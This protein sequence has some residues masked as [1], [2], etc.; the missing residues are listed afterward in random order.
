MGKSL[1]I[2]V[3][4]LLIFI[5]IGATMANDT[6]EPAPKPKTPAPAPKP[7]TPAPAPKPK[8]PAPTPKPK[9]PAPTPKPKTPAPAPKPKAPAPAPKPTAP[10]PAPKPK[11]PAPAPKPKTPAPAPKPKTPPPAPKP[12]TPPPAPK[13][14][15][16]APA[17]KPK[18]P[19][20]APKPKTPAPAP[21]PKTPAPAPK[22]KTPAPA[23][24]PKTPTPAPKPKTPA[25]APKPKTPAPAPKPPKDDDTDY[26]EWTPE[27][28]TGCERAY[29]KSKACNHKIL[30]CP[31]ECPERKPKK[32]KKSK[33]C[34]ISCGRKCEAT[35]KWRR[36]KCNGYG[37]LCYDPRFIGGDGVMFYFHGGKGRDFA[38]VSDTN[39][40]IN[41]HFIGSR[42][43]GRW[44]GEEVT[45]PFDGDAEWKTNT[46]VRQVAVERTDDTN[47]VKVS[48]GGLVSVN[49][50]AVP[51][52]EEDSKVH[53][54]QLPSNDTFAHFELQF[55]FSNLSDDV[56]GIL[57]KTY[58][59]GYVSPVKRGIAMPTMG[60][61]D[62]Y[63]TSSLI[64]PLCKVC[65]F[66]KPSE[67]ALTATDTDVSISQY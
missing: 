21:K 3:A 36:P 10:A 14:K 39:L 30:T 28:K 22:P 65:K 26:D 25:P 66:Q 13:P 20:P 15:T 17:P 33:G 8:T 16:P 46:G 4:F 49:M 63:E 41:A 67:P 2:L 18:T 38:L 7:T 55:E 44:D 45:V 12:K 61:E 6:H 43:N 31:K 42:P 48:V 58:R 34:F 1:I 50:K 9:T 57:G 62:K 32:N 64:S 27:P 59:P 5:S 29:C 37:S 23:P 52:T 40:Q 24:K 19:A 56:E 54:Y 53:N 47:A 35:C 51:V 60:G 11:T